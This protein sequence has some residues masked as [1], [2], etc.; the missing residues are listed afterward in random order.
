MISPSQRP[1]PDN[2]QHSQHTNIQAL[3]GIRTH[4][5]SRRAAVDLR[6]R[7]RGHWDR[8]LLLLLLLLWLLLSFILFCC[9]TSV[10]HLFVLWCILCLMIKCTFCQRVP[11][12]EYSAGNRHV[13]HSHPGRDSC[14]VMNW[15]GLMFRLDTF[16]S[17]ECACAKLSDTEFLL[18]HWAHAMRQASFLLTFL[19]KFFQWPSWRA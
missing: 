11:H 10:C 5:R 19:R 6:L 8:P 4:D 3:G 14:G 17:A 2:T 16:T 13:I 18:C 1:L 9:R 15:W 7:P 12:R